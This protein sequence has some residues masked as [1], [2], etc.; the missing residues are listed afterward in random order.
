MFFLLTIN[1]VAVVHYS[2]KLSFDFALSIYRMTRPSGFYI[3]HKY[4]WWWRHNYFRSL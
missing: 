3:P 2:M 1:I 4:L